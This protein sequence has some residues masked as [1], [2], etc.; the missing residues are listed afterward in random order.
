MMDSGIS[1]TISEWAQFVGAANSGEVA[2]VPT[3]CWFTPSIAAEASQSGQ[4]R[5]AAIP[6]FSKTANSI[7]ASNLGGSSWYVLENVKGS[8]AAVDFLAK[9]F[10]ENADFYQT[11]LTNIGAIGTFTPAQ[12]GAAYDKGVDFFGG[13][14]I[15]K[16]ISSWT[17]KIPS[18]N[19]GLH[20]YAFEDIMKAEMQNVIAGADIQTALKNAQKQ[21]EAQI[22]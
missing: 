9:T 1:K 11:L 20:T 10:G 19:Y 6:R 22:K 16:D 8:D 13:Q 4:W 18:V 7:N 5:V 14:K 21:A 12:T 17:A 2:T 3:G 15:Y